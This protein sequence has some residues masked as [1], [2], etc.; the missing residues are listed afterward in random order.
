[1]RVGIMLFE[2]VEV[3]DF[4][5]PYEVLAGAT[6]Q[7]QPLFEVVT[8]AMSND[9]IC[10]GGLKVTADYTFADC[11]PFDL[12]LVPGGPG[13]RVSEAE[14]APLVDFV[15]SQAARV[16][17]LASVCTGA[18]LLA[19]AG[20]LDGRQATTHY[21]RRQEL[22]DHFPQIKVVAERVVDEGDIVTAAGVSSGVH[23]ALHLVERFG[24][25]ESAH[26]EQK[27]IEWPADQGGC[28][29]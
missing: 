6:H 24:S 11:P 3:L 9:V 16:S 15:R 20:L 28:Q 19:R 8:V 5:G 7:G 29:V 23:L 4:A 14:L 17:Y 10:R 22:Q 13:T 27:R 26:L 12:L 1:M 18:F 25:Q 21:A 2:Q